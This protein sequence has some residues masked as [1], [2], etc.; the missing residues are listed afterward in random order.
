MTDLQDYIR[1]SRAA[2]AANQAKGNRHAE[3]LAEL[4]S[5]PFRFLDEI[6]QNTEDALARKRHAAQTEVIQFRLYEDRLDILH[7]GIDFD[8]AD[9]MAITTFAGTTKRTSSGL[10]QIGKFGIGFRSVY[11]LT[12]HPEIHSGPW[13]FRIDDFEVLS[14]IPCPARSVDFGTLIRLP[15][16]ESEAKKTFKWVQE[17]LRRLNVFSLLFLKYLSA[18]EVYTGETLHHRVEIR[19]RDLANGI[20]RCDVNG[21]PRRVESSA[22][23]LLQETGSMATGAPALAFRL[24]EETAGTARIVRCEMPWLFAYFPTRQESHLD[25]LVHAP[26]TTTPTREAVPL[27]PASAPEN[28]GFLERAARILTRSLVSLRELGFI[29]VSFFEVL[30]LQSNGKSPD[31]VTTIFHNSIKKALCTKPILPADDGS[32]QRAE[33][34]IALDDPA[35]REVLDKRAL[36]LLVQRPACLHH[37][38]LSFPATRQ[39]LL[40]L[41]GIRELTYKSMAFRMAVAPDF[42]TQMPWKWYLRF[43]PFLMAHPDLWDEWHQREHYS[44][45]LKP[46]L[47]LKSGRN[48]PAFDEQGLGSLRLPSG[49]RTKAGDIHPALLKDEACLRFFTMLGLDQHREETIEIPFVSEIDAGKVAADAELLPEPRLKSAPVPH[50]EGPALPATGSLPFVPD[51][52]DAYRAMLQW[53]LEFARTLLQNRFPGLD[54]SIATDGSAKLLG[55]NAQKHTSAFVACRAIHQHRFRLPLKDWM[56]MQA[57]GSPAMLLL[58]SAAGTASA[59]ASLLQDPAGHDRAGRFLC[60]PLA[61]N[62]LGDQD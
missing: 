49:S 17:G 39:A 42:L 8:E 54:W 16:R 41:T 15:F 47:R 28:T 50:S 25:F 23:L 26:F 14:E 34:L 22:W 7:N 24:Q 18:F 56:A 55:V 60:D 40:A 43:Y 59:S 36:P 52:P 35:L 30:P 44:L 12:R 9:L 4:Y 10:Y 61:F 27:D 58:V 2:V 20:S 5:D 31:P 53:S 6:L 19:R 51:F 32:C 13:H 45:R 38:F 37:D 1:K 48:V 29:C 21:T 11:A 62:F 3:L 33:A 46:F 57:A